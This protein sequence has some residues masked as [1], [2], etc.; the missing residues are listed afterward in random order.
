[1]AAVDDVA[2]KVPAAAAG[3]LR[4]RLIQRFTSKR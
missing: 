1:M 4:L 3:S 2:K